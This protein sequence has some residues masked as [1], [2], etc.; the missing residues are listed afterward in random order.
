MYSN[1]VYFI[2][3]NSYYLTLF[4]PVDLTD[5]DFRAVELFPENVE[6]MSPHL[7]F[8]DVAQVSGAWDSIVDGLPT[9]RSQGQKLPLFSQFMNWS[10]SFQ[11]LKTSNMPRRLST[12]PMVVRPLRLAVVLSDNEHQSTT[13][14][15]EARRRNRVPD[16]LAV[17]DVEATNLGKRSGGG[18]AVVNLRNYG[19][20]LEC[21][22]SVAVI[23]VYAVT[24]TIWVQATAL[25]SQVSPSHGWAIEAAVASA[26][27]PRYPF[28]CS[29]HPVSLC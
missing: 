1:S 16:C 4:P 27:A 21:V 25:L 2:H 19:K 9:W 3:Q 6:P 5:P 20:W 26:F 11:M 14:G 22:D 12:S 13:Y 17:L 24:H 18:V 15:V 8:E 29:R 28:H 23:V 7:M 10:L